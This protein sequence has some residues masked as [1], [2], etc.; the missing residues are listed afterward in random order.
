MSDRE[1]LEVYAKAAEDYA[2]RF[3]K[4][5]EGD[6]DQFSDLK[7][8]FELLPDN[9]LVLDL[10]CGPGQWAAKIREAGYQV[11]AMDASP[12]M[13]ALAKEQFDL[14]VTV[15]VF[16]DLTAEARYDGI[17]ANFSLLHA[18]RAD[19]PTHLARIHRALRPGGAFHIGMKLGT[20]EARDGLGR[21]YSYYGEAELIDLLEAAGFTVIR[22]RRGNG[23]GLAGS[24]DTFVI[25]TA[26]G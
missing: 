1:T 10:G 21:F 25:L 9:G 26:H 3:G 8:L 18:P 22:K 20:A 16:E 15:G 7:A 17:W 4:V 14:D 2:A 5:A 24:D 11:E 12:E 23:K 19:F 13:A 6:I